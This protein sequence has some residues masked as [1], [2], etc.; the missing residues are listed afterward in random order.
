[1][2]A[3]TTT[4]LHQLKQ[5]LNQL[6]QFET[7]DLDFGVYKILHYK[8]KEIKD[9]IEN[10]LINKVKEQL[11]TLSTEESAQLREQLAELEKED[12][13]KGWLEADE[14]KRKTLEIF[15]K[16]KINQYRALKGQVT[17]ANVSVET[18]NQIYNHLTLFFSRY[19]DKGDFIS[20]RRFGKNEKYMVPYNGEETHF[21]W[22][23]HDQYYIKSSETFQQ[24]AFKVP[25]TDGTLV[26][27]FKLHEAQLEQG[28]VKAEET[29]YFVLHPD[30][31]R[32]TDDE[33]TFFFDY[34]PLDEA[35]KARVKGS[36]KQD[37]LDKEAY[38][39]LKKA[40]GKIPLLA[41]LWR[42]QDGHPLLLK[43][44]HHYTRKNKHD[45]FI[46][47]NLKGFLERELD[48]YIKSELISVDD[49]YVTDTEAHFD[50][51][52]HRL[53][54]IKVFKSIADTIID[55][56]TQIEDFQKKLWEKKKFVLRTEWVI[57]LDRL[58]AYLGEEAA[59][60]V[61]EEVLA[62]DAQVTEWKTLFGEKALDKW[63]EVAIDD[64]LVK[65]SASKQG[66]IN[67]LPGQ[68]GTKQWKKLPVDTKHFKVDFKYSLLH[69]L[70]TE[71][72]LEEST[73]GLVL[74][75]DNYQGLNLIQDKYRE[76]INTIY[77]DPPYNSGSNDFVYKDSFRNSS[78]LSMLADRIPLARDLMAPDALF[79]T[80]I[81]DKDDKNKVTHRLST[82][83]EAEFGKEN[84]IENVIWVKNT[85]HNDAKTFSHNHEYI[86]SY[87]KNKSAA[88]QE[89]ET[90]RRAKPGFAE[91]QELIHKLNKEYPT[92]EEISEELR[93][94][95]REKDQEYRAEI[96]ALGLEWNEETKRNSPWKGIKQYKYADYRTESGTY[97]APENAAKEKAFIRVY[98][99][100]DPSWPNASTLTK[101]HKDSTSN[102]YR[103]YEPV[104]PVTK[105]VCSAPSRGWIWRE[106]ANPD[107]RG[108]S[109]EELA[110]N[111]EIHF[112]EDENKIPQTK[113]FLDKV[114]TDVMKSVLSDFTDGEKELANVVGQRGTFPNPKPTTIVR[115]LLSLSSKKS[116]YVLDF[117]AGSG[118][119]AQSTLS[120]NDLDERNLSFILQDMAQNVHRTILPRIKKVAYTFDWKDGLPKDGSM[121]GLG[122]F[123][124]YQR[125]EQ[126]EEAL[127]NIAFTAP[128]AATQ[129]ALA[130]EQYIPKYFLEFETRGSQSLVNTAAMQDPWNYTL[131]VWDGF[132]YDTERAVDL[133]ET[134]N[135]LIGLHLQKQLT[136]T[137]N[138]R[139][140]QFIVGHNNAS[141][142]IVVVWRST[143]DWT[144]DDFRADAEALKQELAALLPYDLLYLNDQA[145]LDGYQPI[146]EIFKNKML[147]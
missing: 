98:R 63:D 119:T 92:P 96:E 27:N 139:R 33:A 12:L 87:T 23:N 146:E 100:S 69:L 105:K 37:A 141:K 24:Y 117:F 76:L 136:K 36:S 109:F 108:T 147:P 64:L 121:N 115:T 94:L 106:K 130:F 116:G 32:L 25:T 58:V 123:M 138:G 107:A 14:G 90:F 134:F 128:A 97:V 84:Y 29:N 19:Y 10:L 99:E 118:T 30:A 40:F 85:T 65:V 20:K 51:L 57:T 112:G 46:H 9:F 8:K 101:Q 54:T 103:F 82:L 48:F 86:Q 53:K 59:R 93:K 81:D 49:L 132:T 73:N 104:H 120:L 74:E 72:N 126:Y 45:F 3:N 16:D 17:E 62:N 13:I 137:L 77:I 44:L 114:S 83:L 38:E 31:T 95:Y 89:H 60:P 42:E 68:V 127:E 67:F 39:S 113:R 140:Y 28:N 135:Y 5:F 61:L 124:K 111:H 102:E 50:R 80:S 88:I 143:Q 1:M 26:V 144:L 133:V 129:Q 91:V 78:W 125:L 110:A 75:S 41:G 6:F 52:K 131:H 15:G 4:S 35:E 2:M 145:H 142:Q 34:R 122:I 22:T 47:K 18:E 43:K 71:V 56:V 21:H 7:Q 11:H 70:S 66:K 55:F 79:F